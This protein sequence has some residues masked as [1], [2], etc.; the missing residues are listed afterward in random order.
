MQSI[1][2]RTVCTLLSAL[3]VLSMFAGLGFGASAESVNSTCGSNLTWTFDPD[4]GV[5]E[6]S[7]TGEMT[8]ESANSYGR[9]TVPWTEYLSQ[10]DTV[11]IGSGVTSID[12][13]AFD[14]CENLTS[15]TIPGSVTS[16]GRNA[17]SNCTNL[18]SVTI[19]DGITRIEEDTFFQCSS[20]ASVTIPDGVTSIGLGAF[21]FCLS[22]T[23]LTIPD[24]VTSIERCA[25]SRCARLTSITLSNSLTSI[26]DE[27]FYYCWRLPSITIPD[28]VTSIG[29]N[30]FR[31]CQSLTSVT[32]PDSVTSISDG[33]FDECTSLANLTIPDSV[34]SIG[35]EAFHRTSITSVTIPDGVTSIRSGVFEECRNLTSVTIPDSVTS[36][37]QE[38]FQACTSLA[39][40]TIPDSVTV[41]G[42]SAFWACSAL[43][44]V[45][46]PS[47]VTSI[48]GYAFGHCLRLTS[49]TIPESVTNIGKN[50]FYRCS[51][52]PSLTIP[53][54]VTSIGEATFSYCFSLSSIMIPNSVTSI[55]REAFSY[56]NSLSSVMIPGSVTSVGEY[57][58]CG[59]TSLTSVTIPVGTTMIG[60]YAFQGCTDLT[61]VHISTSVTTIGSSVFDSC[62]NLEFICSE[63]EDCYAKTYADTNG[64]EFRVG[65]FAAEVTAEPTCTEDGVMTYTCP[66]GHSYIET[67]PALGHLY[68]S[69]VTDPTC[70]ADGFTTYTC[71]RCADAY[72]DDTVPALGHS[73][74][75]P[76]WSWTTDYA[77]TAAFSCERGDDTQILQADVTD[78][79]TTEPTFAANGV[80][81]YSASVTFGGAAYTDTATEAIPQLTSSDH[82]FTYTTSGNTLT[83]EC[84]YE[85]CALDDN[86]VTITLNAPFEDGAMDDGDEYIPAEWFLATLD[87]VDDFRTLTGADVTVGEIEY[88]CGETK[89]DAAPTKTV[90]GKFTAKV[91]VTVNGTAY[92]LEQDYMY[93]HDYVYVDRQEPTCTEDGHTEYFVCANCGKL[94]RYVE[95][96]WNYDWPEITEAD[97]VIPA[98]GHD[99][100]FTVSTSPN[101]SCTLTA[102]CRNENCTLEDHSLTLWISRP[103]ARYDIDMRPANRVAVLHGVDGFRSQI[104]E[105]MTVSEIEYYEKD[106]GIKLD[107]APTAA[108][109]YI[110]KTT[111]TVN[112][113]PYELQLVYDIM[114][115]T[116]S[117]DPAY[118]E[119]YDGV[120][121]IES[122]P[123]HALPVGGVPSG[124]TTTRGTADPD[125]ECWKITDLQNGR[126][127]QSGT[128][129]GFNDNYIYHPSTSENNLYTPLKDLSRKTYASLY[130][131]YQNPARETPTKCVD[132]FSVLY[133]VGSGPWT[134]LFKTCEE[135]DG[136]T[137]C[138]IVLPTHALQADFQ[139]CFHAK[140]NNGDGVYLDS[141]L[142]MAEEHDLTFSVNGNALTATC[143]HENCTIEDR[144]ASIWIDFMGT[145][146]ED[147]T[148]SYPWDYMAIINV[149][150]NEYWHVLEFADFIENCSFNPF[151]HYEIFHYYD[152]ET[153]LDEAPTT[154]GNYTVTANLTVNG[155]EYLLSKDYTIYPSSPHDQQSVTID[156]QIS[157][158]FLLDLDARPDVQSV[159][160]AYIDPTTGAVTDTAEY[161]DF[162]GLDRQ[163]GLYKIPADVAPAQIGDT[164]RATIVY[165]ADSTDTLSTSVA[166][167]CKQ[168]LQGDFDKS[169]KDLAAATLEYGQAANDYFAGAGFCEPVEIGSTTAA[170]AAVDAVKTLEST[171]LVDAGGKIVSAS[172][173]ALTKPEFRFYTA[174]LTEAEA[175]A[176]NDKITVTGGAAAQFVKNADSGEILLEVTGIDAENMDEII[177]VSIDGFGSVTFSGNDFARILANNASTAVLGAALYNY[178]AAAKACFA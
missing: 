73:Y 86:Q 103:W 45:R 97:A 54:S 91:T 36:I 24:S 153:L 43:T 96:M 140:G 138:M 120:I 154:A 65:A 94:F 59:C 98:A 52:L 170:A 152:G 80:R 141:I 130:F 4:T 117:T 32:I 166:G 1:M 46:I 123:F 172:F 34:T 2:K 5:L 42:D 159:T 146:Y 104:D 174:G 90:G 33:A 173:M 39:S 11:V 55:G 79:V 56:C 175:A 134:E 19:P 75:A 121:D 25:F 69:V 31:Y 129:H 83:A 116:D 35:P 148:N 93:Y 14:K 126:T 84:A 109:E 57:A 176:L 23:S 70:T 106:S 101:L 48:G 118:Y 127:G 64:I 41:I 155:T 28:G 7:G 178:G 102:T 74:G 6:I 87:G 122:M 100:T 113:T 99:C 149:D 171:L 21:E 165:A 18:A 77:A 26:S 92:G 44:S 114:H 137:W 131:Y 112:G 168:L 108:G 29:A 20:L 67:L 164:I 82:K 15:V 8:F 128:G 40:V 27:L 12:K 89:L 145:L 169:V 139:L 132:E 147:N 95:D 76:V 144:E 110:A 50:A 124:W 13:Y 37:G 162:S 51:S 167:Y 66:C 158:N 68:D 157:V 163:G 47:S 58:F 60:K 133:R 3:M 63:T 16:I 22:L 156:D 105:N 115:A 177:T 10:I 111:V 9:P 17:F 61:S 107:A 78:E 125:N 85:I 62:E 49:V 161:T 71:T 150:E 151:D 53:S 143:S 119:R 160:I 136:W 142:L 81:T 38:A 135:H 30:A 72:T 88:Y